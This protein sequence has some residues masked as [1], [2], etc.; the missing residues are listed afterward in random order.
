MKVYAFVYDYQGYEEN[1]VGIFSSL[2]EIK[3]RSKYTFNIR[4]YLDNNEYALVEWELNTN[5][6]RELKVRL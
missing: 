2:E 1:V 3:E 5:K 6:K 4:K